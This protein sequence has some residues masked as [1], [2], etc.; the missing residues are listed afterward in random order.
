MSKV[1]QGQLRKWD[2]K[3]ELGLDSAFL[4]IRVV[5]SEEFENLDVRRGQGDSLWEI[6]QEGQD[7]W[8]LETFILRDSVVLDES[9]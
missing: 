3:H 7:Y 4:V 1:E 2:D 9:T 8:E 6:L 5:E